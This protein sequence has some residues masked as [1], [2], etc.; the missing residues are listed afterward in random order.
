V[1]GVLEAGQHLKL[2]PVGIKALE[3]TYHGPVIKLADLISTSG[4][5][6]LGNEP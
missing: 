3:E 2:L 6:I 1:T 4:K 5:A